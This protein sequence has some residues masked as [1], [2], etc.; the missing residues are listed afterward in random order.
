M[1][2]EIRKISTFIEQTLIEGGKLSSR[3]VNIVV[4][5]AVIRNPWAGRGFVDNLRPEIIEV[6]DDLSHKMTKLIL[7]QMPADKIEA[8]GKAAAVGI[9]GEIEHASAVIHTLRFGNPF[10]SA[11]GGTNYLEFANT[12]NAPGALM[13]LPMMHKSENGKRSHFLTANF[14]IA[15]APGP[16]EIMVS[17]GVSDNGRAH[18]RIADRFQD[19][20]EMEAE[21]NGK[22]KL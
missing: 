4:V 1:T 18:A 7:E 10:R 19:I 21:Q 8:C 15:D 5:A 16:D 2:L 20:A 9:N 22:N 12:R 3:P 6:A 11:I 17:L 14:M 13:S